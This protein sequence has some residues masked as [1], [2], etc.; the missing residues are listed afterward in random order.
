MSILTDC[1]GKSVLPYSYTWNLQFR[2]RKAMR[3]RVMFLMVAGLMSMVPAGSDHLTLPGRP[4]ASENGSAPIGAEG[5][6]P[7]RSLMKTADLSGAAAEAALLRNGSPGLESSPGSWTGA[8][9]VPVVFREEAPG[10]PE[11]VTDEDTD[12]LSEMLRSKELSLGLILG[13]LALALFLGAAHGLEPG[14]GKTVVA[15]YLVGSR[16][17]VGNALFLGGVVTFTHTFSVIMLGLVALFATQYVQPEQIFPWLGTLSGVLI[18]ALGIWLLIGHLKRLDSRGHPHHH[19]HHGD[20]GHD[21]SHP[22]PEDHGHS[23]EGD[24]PHHDHGHSHSHEIPDKVTL[25]S[26]LALGVSGG[27]VPCHGALVILLLA[28]AL[29]RI[30]FGL[31]LLLA[32]S[33]GLAAVLIAIG[34]LMVKAR[35][36]V[37]RFSGD[38]R[39]IQRLPV[40]SAVVII[41]VGLGITVKTLMGSGIL[42]VHL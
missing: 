30:A 7:G 38:S 12:V 10:G 16:G 27:I 2:W 39:W 35:P 13:A 18:V 29:H 25:G 5:I 17:T 14:H 11:G 36:L 40:V 42:S 21:H 22:H 4:A 33:V 28:V 3:I 23:H 32:F 26:L 24:D 31:L 8:A 9:A 37:D 41:A 15:A 20:H 6:A 19:H 34:V 1:A